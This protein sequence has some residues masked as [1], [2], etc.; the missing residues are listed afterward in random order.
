MIEEIKKID[1][2]KMFQPVK[3]KKISFIKKLL[4]IMGYGK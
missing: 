4:K 2:S 1:K 3:Q